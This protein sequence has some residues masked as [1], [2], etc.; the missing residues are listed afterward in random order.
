MSEQSSLETKAQL[1]KSEREHL[2]D[3]V[4]GLRETVEADIEY[5]LEHTYE[6]NDEDGG[7]NLFGE[8]A[9]T[10][11]EL[12]KAVEREDEDKIWEDKFERYVMGVGYTIVNRL[13]A[14]RC[15]EVRGFIDRPVTQFGDSGT[16]PA[17]E[18][19]EN[20]QYLG[21]DEAKI[22]AYDE[23]CRELT[24]EIEILFDPESPY[25]IIKPDVEIFEEL[26]R[27][28]DDIPDEVW[29]ADDVL[30]WVYEYYNASKLDEL[31]RKGDREGLD[32]EDVPPANQFY[33][34][35]WVVRMLTDNSLTKMYLES[36][37]ELL[38]TIDEQQ[39]LS[40]EDRKFRAVSPDETPS[41][42]DFS[43]FLVPAEDEGEAPDFEE[44]KEIRV[45]D[46]ACGSGH[47]LLY[48]FDVLERIWHRERP[49]LDRAEI[50][51]KI[52]RHNLYGIDLDLRACQLAA[53]NLY[54]KARGRSE[55]EGRAYFEMPE[56]GI[57][58]ADAKIANVEAAS[59][60]FDEV[61][62]DQPEVR[63]ALEDILGA[64]ENVQGLGSLLDVK[65]TLEDEFTM[66]EQPTLMEAISG[67]GSLSTF[68]DNL[69]QEIAEQRNGESFLAQDLKSFL[70]VLVILSQDYDVALMNPPYGTRNRMPDSVKEYVEQHY[71]YHPEFYINFF[72]VCD[73]LTRKNGRI[74][75]L[76]PR[77][78]MFKRSFEEFRQD[79]VGER[80]AFD[81]LAEYGI[82]VLDNATVRTV[83]TVVRTD[84]G[85]NDES[86]G[87]FFR[88]HDVEKE[89]KEQKFLQSA[90]VDSVDNTGVQRRYT[91]T[92]GEF[93]LIPGSPLTYWVSTD[94]RKIYDS[95]IVL[96]ADNARVDR[97]SQGAVKQGL[98]TANDDRFA[99]K[100]WET[101]GDEWVPF[102]KGGEDVWILPRVT[103]TIWWN[104]G[105]AE[106]RRYD[107]SYLRNTDYYF[108]DALSFNRIKEGG[109]R[110]G[111]LSPGSVF[112]DTS[113]VYSPSE[114]TLQSLSYCNS[115]LITYLVL[116]QTVGRHWN[117]GE[118]S[119]LPWDPK[120]GEIELLENGAKEMISYV[121]GLR[122]NDFIS[123]YY[124]GP[125]LLKVLGINEC[126][127]GYDY[128]HREL[129]QDIQPVNPDQTLSKS[130]SLVE[131]G[132]AAEKY[133]ARMRTELEDT[134]V[135]IDKK[136]FSHFDIDNEDQEEIL[137]EIAL[138]TN[139]DPR[140]STEQ[141][142][143]DISEVTDEFNNLVKDLLLHLSIKI[144]DE[145]KDG[146]VP[147]T[148]EVK[149]EPPLV[150]RLERE[151][152]RI[153]NEYGQDRLAEVDT[154][155]GDKTPGSGAYPNI[156]SWIEQDL[157]KYHIRRFEN[158]PILW[159]L[160]TERLVSD[161]KMEG[162]ACLVDYNK[163][164]AGLFD[165]I[166]SRYLE[167]LKNEYRK[168]RNA[169]DQRR[170]DE[171]LSTT[172][173]AE[174]AEEYERYESAL[175]Q[176][177]EFQEVA[178]EL[179]SEHPRDWDDEMQS[180]TGELAP[181]VAEFRYR[182]EKRLETLDQLVNEMDPGEF[183]DLFSPTFLERVNENRDE[184]IDALQDLETACMAYSKDENQPVEAHLYDLFPYFDDLVGST[185][186][187]SNGIFFMNYYFSKGED[188]L[189]NGEPREGLEGEIK[190]LA[191]L[192]AETDD[193]V[194][195]GKE[196][197]E[198]CSE[199][200][201]AIPSNWQ[202]RA[203]SEILTPGYDP[204]QKHGVAINV[205]PLADKKIVPEIVKDKVIN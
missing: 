97:K 119:K 125:T 38:S 180:L 48:A 160:T 114:A 194:E 61:A 52:L 25:S 41:L 95:E 167:P 59:E 11:A 2:E 163:L 92:I 112:S 110:F 21:P 76:V 62:G 71:T 102:A 106:V 57:V 181:K 51:K 104:N 72:E 162:F 174:A 83:G 96:D 53:F 16:T 142:P 191:E 69:H 154:Q 157:F 188:Y 66:E 28:L 203:L 109:R 115:N 47:F 89:E 189:D 105:G 18:K 67:P 49:D 134:A 70:R 124:N 139:I 137:R 192:A 63:R 23:I 33:T 175:T 120:L 15:M 156:Q 50:P 169:A 99:R 36:K 65:G 26:C 165:Q 98:A 12:V 172:E 34:P 107:G 100:F 13:T 6:L 173:Q 20:E 24:D 79:F 19:L 171:L 166:E 147:L 54:L 81:F 182:T 87:E 3:V 8:G 145:D 103:D 85:L 135:Q 149:G 78:F 204:V 185:H 198:K 77:T 155:L 158:T 116:A 74:G 86:T 127:P 176:I 140:K 195:L 122:Q 90:Y 73:S 150:E 190:L 91:K 129:L 197:R 151:F 58:C 42:A 46:P 118:V 132:L 177:N 184:W 187:G 186:Y 143:G 94:I 131:L 170:S 146:I 141:N 40:T 168:R 75:M 152:E 193:D 128:K 22:E 39:D 130:D 17:A 153:F 121:L 201:K 179:G 205:Q 55:E 35:H 64:F 108:D 44:P 7:E 159:Q 178:L 111:Y 68:L 32:P 138:R 56:I 196:I 133:L 101:R 4:T 148:S 88:L 43:T 14:L 1:D 37:G 80:G 27:K 123:P 84:Q 9:D 5:Q 144:V 31:R 93:S 183:E 45:I 126:L 117:V 199:L 30:G 136:I 10:R 164:T 29:R 82:G 113:M 200:S 202:D 60:V 161:P